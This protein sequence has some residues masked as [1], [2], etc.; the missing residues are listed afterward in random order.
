MLLF[1]LLKMFHRSA[2][3]FLIQASIQMSPLRIRLPSAVQTKQAPAHLPSHFLAHYPILSSLNPL[4]VPAI[5]LFVF[6][7][8]FS[9]LLSPVISR[10]YNS[11]RHIFVFQEIFVS[12]LTETDHT[13][14]HYFSVSKYFPRTS[15][16]GYI[17][18]LHVYRYMMS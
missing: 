14:E 18:L 3:G 11:I 4:A 16:G 9:P 7:V 6:I 1:P 10:T 2:C 12:P 8:C 5:H 17:Q 13:H 15:F